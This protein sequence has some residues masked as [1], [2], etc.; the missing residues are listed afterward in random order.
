MLRDVL[1]VGNRKRG[2]GANRANADRVAAGHLLV[3]ARAH[4]LD[5]DGLT[6]RVRPSEVPE[7]PAPTAQDRKWNT[8]HR[9]CV[10]SSHGQMRSRESN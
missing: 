3:Q 8:R 2:A 5:L 6:G 1:A 7:H 9:S 10:L 4:Q